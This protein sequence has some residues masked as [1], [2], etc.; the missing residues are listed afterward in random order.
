MKKLILISLLSSI[1]CY[2]CK[3][4]DDID[5]STIDFSNIENLYAQ[6]LP[7]IQKCVQG[8]W[9]WFVT[10]GGVVG[11]S[12]KDNTF[13][14]IY[15]NH[16]VITSKNGDQRSFNYIWKKIHMEE[17]EHKTW[18]IWNTDENRGVWCFSSIRNDT[19]GLGNTNS[20]YPY[21]AFVWARVKSYNI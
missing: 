6:P 2:G 9:K 17:Y 11:E 13:V 12:Y 14:Y 21:M 16:C 19:I 3:K 1:L 15:D 18:V 10:Y 4:E 7:V 8:K 5:L 20:G